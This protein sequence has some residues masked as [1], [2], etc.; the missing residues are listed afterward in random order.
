MSPDAVI[1]PVPNDWDRRGLPGWTYHSPALFELEREQVF[2]RTWQLAGHVNDL[3]APGDWLTFDLLG[4]RAVVIRGRDGVVR[5]FHNLCRHRGARVV[6]GDSGH[7]KGALVCPFHGWVYNLDG[8]LRGPARPETFGDMDRDCFGLKPVEMEVWQGFLFL[9][10]LPGPQPAVADLL[11]PYTQDFEGF[12]AE[13]LLPVA[14]PD[15]STTLPVNWKSVRDVDNEG[16]HV[17]MAHP[18]LQDLYGRTYR[19]LVY[20][21]GLAASFAEYGDQPGRLWSV[22]QYV[23]LSPVQ[24]WL[25]ERLRRAWNYYGLFPNAVF[26]FT[27]ESVQ[28]YQELPLSPGQTRLTGRIYRQPGEDRQQRLARY[29]AYRI[30]RETSAEDQQLS[31]WSNESMKSQAFDDFHLSDLEFGLRNHHDQLREILPVMTQRQS[32]PEDQIAIINNRMAQ[33]T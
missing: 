26:V 23:K 14:T 5:A 18:G 22:R 29:L 21:N 9:R 31:I 3:P 2:L 19:D 25:P 27:P 24:D 10:F 17:A 16:Y 1:R 12:R 32:P 33:R 8:S 20:Q 28:Y 6:D 15:W 7:C 30:D 13:G 11:A 4:E